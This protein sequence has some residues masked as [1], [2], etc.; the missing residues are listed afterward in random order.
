MDISQ[1]QT[2]AKKIAKQNS[3]KKK[4]LIKR[5]R[6][7]DTPFD[8]ITVA[9]EHWVGMGNFKLSEKVTDKKI[10]TDRID[11]KNWWF[12]TTVIN[13]VIIATQQQRKEEE[14]KQ[15]TK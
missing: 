2:S 6:Y 5:E 1:L 10:L 3:G 11:E 8:I 4:Q 14:I 9:K 7:K 12:I 15:E 13:T